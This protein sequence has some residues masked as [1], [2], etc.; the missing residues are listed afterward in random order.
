MIERLREQEPL[1]ILITAVTG[2]VNPKHRGAFFL[3]RIILRLARTVNYGITGNKYYGLVYGKRPLLQV[4]QLEIT[5]SF[6][7]AYR[8]G[9]VATAG[10]VNMESVKSRMIAS[11]RC[12]RV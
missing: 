12:R 9:A 6:R 10:I 4:D 11:F 8:T 1:Q 7:A 3:K 2:K 5:S